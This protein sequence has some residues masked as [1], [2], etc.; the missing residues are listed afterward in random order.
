M[1]IAFCTKI[2]FKPEQGDTTTHN[3]IAGSF[4]NL[5]LTVQEV[6]EYIDKGYAFSAHH[7]NRRKDSNFLRTGFIAV[8]IDYGWQ[9]EDLLA[10]PFV[11]NYVAIV[12]TTVSHTPQAHRLR[13]LME[14]EEEI[15]DQTRL[16]RLVT[17]AIKF[18]GG[19]KACKSACQ[20]FYGSKGCAP[21]VIGKILTKEQIER[22]IKLGEDIG[23]A[24]VE[25]VD[26]I[27]SVLL[28]H[29]E[30][31]RRQSI[32]KSPTRSSVSLLKNQEVQ[33]ANRSYGML[34]KMTARTSVFCPMHGDRNASA[35][36]VTNESGINGVHCR[37]CNMSFWPEEN[38]R[39]MLLDYD[40]SA[41]GRHVDK[42][43]FDEDPMHLG[44]D[45]PREFWDNELRQVQRRN[46]KYLSDIP[47]RIG[48]TGLVS[49]TG[50]GKTALLKKSVK[51]CRASN[52]TVLVIG[53]RQLLLAEL[54]R[55]L[56]LHFYRDKVDYTKTDKESAFG[57]LAICIDSMPNLLNTA[58]EKYD[59]VI[60]DESEQVFRHL[61]A[62]TLGANRRQCYFQI[63]FFLKHAKSII[64]S[65]A[66]MGFLT[67]NTVERMVGKNRNT[68]IYVNAY[69][70]KGAVID[71]YDSKNHLIVEMKTAVLEGGRHYICCNSKTTALLMKKILIE[72]GK[73]EKK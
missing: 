18:F 16:R 38:S 50:S 3:I 22:L 42:L 52:K 5:D 17:G 28:P 8:D 32:N 1:K 45:A 72:G 51:E 20:M 63:E 70:P 44:D 30:K 26:N 62:K 21:F 23:N 43:E 14:L 15:T 36:V 58:R 68:K 61:V 46:Q 33:L 29:G 60:I 12:Y 27:D 56:D 9:Q 57:Y 2:D 39:S 64:L 7:R 47:L 19:D 24:S 69:K 35:F 41:Y 59:V 13:V 6:A 49:P 37:T 54:A 31:N 25:D 11:K 48:I 4:E 71:L 67:I 66:D 73:A 10:L 53:H 40:F 55:N 34:G 65:D